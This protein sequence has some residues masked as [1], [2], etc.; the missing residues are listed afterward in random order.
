MTF[1]EKVLPLCQKRGISITS[2]ALSVGHSDAT[3][4]K[5]KRGANPR[6]STVKK[7]ADYFNVPVDYFYDH[8]T[9][10]PSAPVDAM[11]QE[12]LSVFHSLDMK[13]KTALL[14]KAYELQEDFK[15]R[16]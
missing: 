6:P 11:E 9:A 4:V 8:P 7:I 12:L 3:S 1:Y 13:R 2:L 15:A 16:E 14:S 5:W 10:A